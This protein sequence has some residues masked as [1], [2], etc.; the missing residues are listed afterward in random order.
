MKKPAK[1][2]PVK[3]ETEASTETNTETQIKRETRTDIDETSQGKRR[4]NQT[5]EDK[6]RQQHDTAER[7]ENKTSQAKLKASVRKVEVEPVRSVPCA[8]CNGTGNLKPKRKY[9]NTGCDSFVI[10]SCLSLIRS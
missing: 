10:T 6:T 2:R 4:Q 9:V 5:R 3:S 8:V 1:Y 7:D